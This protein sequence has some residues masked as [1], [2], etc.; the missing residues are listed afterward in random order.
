MGFFSLCPVLCLYCSVWLNRNWVSRP[1][2]RPPIQQA[3][4]IGLWGR[5]PILLLAQ[6]VHFVEY[7]PK[8]YGVSA[9]TPASYSAPA[10]LRLVSGAEFRSPIGPEGTLCRIQSKNLWC[11]GHDTGLL[12]S[13]PQIGLWGRI[14][15]LLLVQRA[16]FVEYNPKNLWC[17]GHDTG[18]LFSTLGQ[19]SFLLLAH[20]G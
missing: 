15:I 3:S 11:L 13:R 7:N 10:G 2:H 14:P 4:Q 1:R 20:R 12:F 19:N 9:T 17:L 18:P 16:D 6:R 8:I 5:I